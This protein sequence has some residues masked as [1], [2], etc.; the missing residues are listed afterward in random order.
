MRL[1]CPCLKCEKIYVRTYIHTYNIHT[2]ELTALHDC[3]PRAKVL[4]NYIIGLNCVLDHLELVENV[5]PNENNLLCGLY[6]LVTDCIILQE[7]L[8]TFVD[9]RTLKIKHEEQFKYEVKDIL[10]FKIITS[11][12]GVEGHGK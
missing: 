6:N 4:G 3:Q 7:D 1:D 8:L 2:Y 9:V 11:Q 5:F 12:L 10:L